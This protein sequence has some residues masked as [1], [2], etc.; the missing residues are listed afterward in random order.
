MA[1]SVQCACVLV[2]PIAQDCSLKR[3]EL[4]TVRTQTEREAREKRK[5]EDVV[6]EKMMQQ[7]TMDKSTQYTRRSVEGLQAHKEKLVR[8][9]SVFVEVRHRLSFFPWC[10]RRRQQWR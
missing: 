8:S 4:G 2:D 1:D 9:N 7:L 5:L 6:M 3:N 10:G